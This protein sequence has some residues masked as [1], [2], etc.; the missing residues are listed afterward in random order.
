M[1]DDPMDIP[2]VLIAAL[3]G[4]SGKT[5]VTIGIIAA[6]SRQGKTVAPFKKGPDYIDAGWLSLAGGQPCF[7]LDT[8]MADEA[9]VCQSFFHHSLLPHIDLAIIEGNRGLYDGLDV[10]GSTSSASL[11]KLLNVPVVLC[12]DCTK[13]TR[14]MAAVVMGLLHFD[15]DVKIKGVILNQVAGLRHENLL[16]GSIEKYCH[17]PVIGAI[18]KLSSQ[19]FPERHM[20]LIPTPEHEW[21]MESIRAAAEVVEAHVD[22]PAL[23]AVAQT[24]VGEPAFWAKDD[25]D[26]LLLKPD[27]IESTRDTPHR[28]KPKIGVIRDS[29]F[30]FYYPDNLEAL[31]SAGAELVFISPLRDAGLPAIDA[32]YIGGGFPETHAEPLSKNLLF[33][34]EIKSAA[35]KGLPIYAECGGLMYL[36]ES[37]VLDKPYPMAGVIPVVFGFSKKPQGHGYTIAEVVCE[38]PYYKKGAMIRGHEFHYSKVLEWKGSDRDTAFLMR[39]GRGIHQQRDGIIHKNVFATYTHIHALGVREWAGTLVRLALEFAGPK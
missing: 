9:A 27:S 19:Y 10:D 35:E 17:I 2:R 31:E 18:P 13:S 25:P 28:Y 5:I 20:G 26:A 37:L 11:A 6:L 34:N 1:Q 7:N 14:T 22:M 24:S 23:L 4:G 38:N 36:G 32:L 39:K 12:L 16:R 8:F 29:A 15:P 30:Q 3:R 33:R 21:A